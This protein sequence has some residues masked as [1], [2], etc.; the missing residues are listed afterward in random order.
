MKAQCVRRA[1][2]RL[3]GS[4]DL[5]KVLELTPTP[6]ANAF[7]ASPL[8]VA[9]DPVYPLELVLCAQCKHVQLRDVVDPQTLFRDYVY[10][11]GTSPSFVRHFED[12]ARGI[13]ERNAIRRGG[14]VVDVGS[15]DGTL[16]RFFRD[17]GFNVLGID[18]ARDI[19]RATTESG[20]ETL[21]EF[22][23]AELAQ[24]IAR[25]RGRC[26]LVT[27]NN[28]FAHV[29]D[30]AGFVDS[31]RTLLANDGLF[32]FEVS[33]LADVYEK[34][35]FDTIYHEHLD[36]HTVAPLEGF[37]ARHRMQLIGVERIP[38]HGG[39]IRGVAQV[40]GGA[41]KPDRSIAELSA[42]ERKLGL[43]RPEAYADFARRIN[44]VKAE[45]KKVLSGLKKEGLRIAGYG[46][47]A[48]ATTLMY[49]FQIGPETVDFIVDDSPHK[50]GLF[51]P[52]MHI[53]VLPATAIEE[54]NPD[55][56]VVLAWNFADA[57]VAKSTAFLRRG[58]QIVVPLPEVRVVS[59]P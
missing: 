29:D 22:L 8:P 1:D 43:D 32:A 47:P 40:A 19:A 31:V 50:Q 38:T 2:C 14:R 34:C 7:A 44:G 17:S 28:V 10:V 21:P 23:S 35:L 56:L 49:H 6:L 3:C 39:S 46:A 20:I 57:I 27:A 30:L 9:P 33:Y 55:A 16:L 36:Y 53:P 12:Y 45:L 51:S 24:R 42:I 18:P 37:F 58:G 13:V 11:S 59:A 41:R 5:A 4:R 15:N 48:K 25:E 52:G 54:R 26:A